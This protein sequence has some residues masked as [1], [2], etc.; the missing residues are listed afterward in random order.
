VVNTSASLLY[1]EARA[2]ETAEILQ[3]NHEENEELDY[4]YYGL[5]LHYLHALH[6]K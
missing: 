4:C 2:W 5:F 6:D 3:N 1:R